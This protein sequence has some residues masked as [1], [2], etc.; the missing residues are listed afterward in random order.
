MEERECPFCTRGTRE[1]LGAKW[2]RHCLFRRFFGS[3]GHTLVVPRLHVGSVFELL[4][5]D[6]DDLWRLVADARSK[7]I[8][9]FSPA[10]FNI[11][12]ND[13][14]AA[15]QTIPH[16]HVH[17]IPRYKDDVPDPRGGVRWI[18]PTKADYWTK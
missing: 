2:Y 12:I 13:G 1:L 14:A 10:G 8:E 17:L 16:A 5:A 15:G 7:L 4:R 6:L 3:E 9:R 18:I 11:G